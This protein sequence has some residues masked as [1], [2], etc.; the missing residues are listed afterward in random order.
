VRVAHLNFGGT[1]PLN[2][3]SDGTERG[4]PWL[5]RVAKNHN[6][7]YWA[8][9]MDTPPTPNNNIWSHH[10]RKFF[11]D[12]W[13]Y[14]GR[15]WGVT[16]AGVMGKSN[17]DQ[18]T[19]KSFIAHNGR[20]WKDFSIEPALS[21]MPNRWYRVLIERSDGEFRFS[22]NGELRD[23]GYSSVEGSLAIEENCLYHYNRSVRELN[24]ACLIGDFLQVGDRYIEVWPGDEAYDDYFMLGDPHIN[25]YEGTVLVDSLSIEAL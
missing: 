21:Y 1:P 11:I 18:N 2:G 14:P 8:A 24:E 9:I 6:G 10:H 4:S 19:G 12:T 20:E 3:C 23:L 5:D 22:V 7:V 25:F 17:T 15:M 16:V 13:N